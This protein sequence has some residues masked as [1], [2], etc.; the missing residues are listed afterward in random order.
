MSRHSTTP[1]STSRTGN[2]SAPPIVSEGPP[3][4]FAFAAL[5]IS[6]ALVYG[7]AL[8][9]PFF[10]DDH[11]AI[12]N[13]A[14]I[15]TLWPLIGAEAHRGPLNPMQELPTSSR[16]LVNF[17]FALNYHFGGLNPVGYHVVNVVIHFLCAILLFAIVRRML[18]LAWFGGRFDSAA[19]WLALAAALLWSLHPLNTEAVIY[20]TQRTE[21]MMAWFYLA[22]LYCSLRYWSARTRHSR[23][24]WL[25]LAVF[26]SLAGMLSKEVM[27]S[28]PLVILLFDRTFVTGS[29]TSSLRKSWPLYLGLA[30][31]WIPLLLFIASGP[32]SSSSGFHLIDN[33]FVYWLTQCKVLL[34]YLKL[35][36]WSWPLRCSYELPRVDTFI[37]ALMYVTPVLLIS[38][39]AAW[40]FK[41]NRSVGFTL[42]FIAAILAPTSI[43]P[44]PTEMAAERRMYLP[45]AALIVLSVVGTFLFAK[46]QVTLSAVAG[47]STSVST[48]PRVVAFMWIATLAIVYGVISSIRLLDYYNETRMWQQV[49][50]SQ[51]L[52]YMAHY[53]LGLLYNYAGREPDSLTELQAAVAAN[54]RYPNARS[55]LGF[56]LISAGR[57]PEAI[58]SIQTALDFNPDHVGALNNI[59]IA[60]TKLGKYPEAIENLRR[61]IRIDPGHADAHNN[62]G[63]ALIAAGRTAE[64]AEH[65]QIARS[66][67]PDDPDVLYNLAMSHANNNELPQAIK[68]FE[69]ALRV[70]P[71]FAA[72]HNGLGIALHRSGH[73]RGAAEHFQRFQQLK[74]NEAGAYTNLAIVATGEEAIK[75]FQKALELNPKMLPAY[76]ALAN[77]LAS[78]NRGDE[79]VTVAQ[80]GIEIARS[81]GDQ[82]TV[83]QL[84]EWLA[85]F[86]S[87]AA[88]Q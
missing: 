43:M 82:A 47:Q 58:N 73:V 35:A 68:L 57:L 40:L 85:R 62:L 77:L 21:L 9:A 88:K 12:T 31:T 5:V 6:I 4:W 56:A 37:A 48:T 36:V 69:R 70:R 8:D 42:F 29:F 46:R 41:R 1:K 59:G 26:A 2:A 79:A 76:S 66:L 74:P 20:I 86:Q 49:A 3:N 53:N 80:R 61:A 34:M 18:R 50:D 28:A 33:L 63:Q 55:A 23:S 51:P 38:L 71:D 14:S 10:F 54:P 87:G 44:I 32:R 67:T 24:G 84:Q 81:L 17:S 27:A 15:R 78:A 45:L 72:A 39:L 22:T 13:N 19:G 75:D 11:A 30:V 25:T 64:A 83:Q 60:L 65:L 16:P 52:N 7:R